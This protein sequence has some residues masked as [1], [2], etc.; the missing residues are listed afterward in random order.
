VR[1]SAEVKEIVEA[2]VARIAD[3]VLRDAAARALIEPRLRDVPWEYGEEGQTYPCW[4]VADLRPKSTFV[5][6]YC[7][8][9]FGPEHPFGILDIDLRSMGMDSQWYETLEGGLYSFGFGKRPR[10]YEVG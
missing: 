9:G 7:E 10:G 8:H 6:A 1:S 2:Q 4:I 3:P 5:V